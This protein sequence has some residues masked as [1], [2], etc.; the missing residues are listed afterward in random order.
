MVFGQSCASGLGYGDT[1]A[2]SSGGRL[3]CLRSCLNHVCVWACVC[4]RSIRC[5]CV[6]VYR[7]VHV[8]HFPSPSPDIIFTLQRDLS[9][10]VVVPF[11]VY[12]QA[13]RV[14]HSYNMATFHLF[15]V[16]IAKRGSGARIS[17]ICTQT[18][19]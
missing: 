10:F 7:N 4:C 15:I 12:V 6:C 11:N 9:F 17:K 18:Y 3:E 19:L 2:S 16:N 13:G 8:N 14:S 1:G 5:V